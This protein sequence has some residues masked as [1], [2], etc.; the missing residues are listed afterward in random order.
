MQAHQLLYSFAPIGY[1]ELARIPI[2]ARMD[3]IN[4]EDPTCYV[5]IEGQPIEIHHYAGRQFYFRFD[6]NLQKNVVHYCAIDDVQILE[7]V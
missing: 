2:L 6:I 3:A 4:G 1:E 5:L 7:C